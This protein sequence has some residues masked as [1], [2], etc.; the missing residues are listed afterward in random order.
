MRYDAVKNY[1]FLRDS[2]RLVLV[3]VL[4]YREV[5]KNCMKTSPTAADSLVSAVYYERQSQR[6]FIDGF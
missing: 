2:Q 3:V 5:A 4:Q 1:M 6:W